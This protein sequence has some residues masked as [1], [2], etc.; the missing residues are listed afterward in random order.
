V[1]FGL[2]FGGVKC[3]VDV[4]CDGLGVFVDD[5]V[6]FVLWHRFVDVFGERFE[7]SLADEGFVIF[8]IDSLALI[9][10]AG[11]AMRG[12]NCGAIGRGE[13]E[14]RQKQ[15]E[16]LENS[17]HSLRTTVRDGEFIHRFRELTQI[18]KLRLAGLWG[19]GSGGRFEI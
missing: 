4:R 12:V 8:V 10:V 14:R 1:E 15:E 2:C 13:G 16:E 11:G 18:F 9:S 7:G 17:W 6:F 5:E 19:L 3:G